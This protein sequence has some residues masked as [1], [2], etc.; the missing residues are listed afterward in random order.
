MDDFRYL[1]GFFVAETGE[2]SMTDDIRYEHTI[3][4]VYRCYERLDGI[5]P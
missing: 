2:A 5:M 1:V 4:W 3:N